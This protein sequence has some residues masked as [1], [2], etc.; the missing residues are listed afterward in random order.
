MEKGVSEI[1]FEKVS[2]FVGVI[3]CFIA[4]DLYRKRDDSQKEVDFIEGKHTG[5]TLTT[6]IYLSLLNK[7]IIELNCSTSV[8][9]RVL[10]IFTFIILFLAIV[11]AYK[12]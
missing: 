6:N 3:L 7:N 8:Y 1:I 5:I 9:S 2:K 4:L 12:P 10:A 11:M